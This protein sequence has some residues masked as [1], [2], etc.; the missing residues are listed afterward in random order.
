MMCFLI[1]ST[2][3]YPVFPSPRALSERCTLPASPPSVIAPRSTAHKHSPLSHRPH[4][5]PPYP[6]VAPPRPLAVP[7][8]PLAAPPSP[9]VAPPRPLVA[10]PRPLV[11]PPRPFVAPLS[12][13]FLLVDRLPP[14]ATLTRSPC[15]ARTPSL[16]RTLVA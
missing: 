15:A 6:L 8:H 3:F 12:T 2:S 9:L 1:F 16:Q 5:T 14:P 10:P 4:L 11:A 13:S 7:P